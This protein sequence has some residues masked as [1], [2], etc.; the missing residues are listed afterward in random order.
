[1]TTLVFTRLPVPGGS[2]I[3]TRFGQVF[4]LDDGIQR[5]H[6][7]VD[8]GVP[9][10]TPIVAP[11]AGWIV[12][13]T[14]DGS[15][16]LAVC[17]E[18]PG[19]PWYSL[20]AHLSRIDVAIGQWVDT[21]FQLGKSGNTG[22]SSGPHLHWQVCNTKAFPPDITRSADPLTFLAPLPAQPEPGNPPGAGALP[23]APV[24]A[25]APDFA[26]MNDA[27]QQR[28]ELIRI[29]LHPDLTIVTRALH[30]ARGAI[31]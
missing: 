28:F 29:A 8:F 11:A 13:F 30:A 16:G 23:P 12:D 4:T 14:N 3:T 24:P 22:L 15:F 7:G 10:G 17:I 31:R 9:E 20:Y 19:T 27:L 1:M 21:G 2:P 25:A 6:R 5:T 26:I 18:H